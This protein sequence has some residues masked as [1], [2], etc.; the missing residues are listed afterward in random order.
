M[1]TIPREELQTIFERLAFPSAL[2][3]RMAV[4][5]QQKVRA[6]RVPRPPDH[7]PWRISIKDAKEFVA[8]AGQRQILSRTQPFDRKI[9]SGRLDARWAA[10]IISHVAP[11]AKVSWAKMQFI[12]IVQDIFSRDIWT[13]ALPN[14]K[15]DKAAQEF[16]EILRESRRTARPRS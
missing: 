10:D 7:Q 5:S 2:Q 9:A 14:I 6:A 15:A 11:P 3:L 1:T 13:R 12:L 8:K 4:L 16:R